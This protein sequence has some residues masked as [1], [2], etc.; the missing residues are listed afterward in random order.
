MIS[1][2]PSFERVHQMCNIWSCV[3]RSYPLK[4]HLWVGAYFSK[5]SIKC[6]YLCAS[7]STAYFCSHAHTF[8]KL[9]KA[10]LCSPAFTQYAVTCF[11]A[12]CSDM[13]FV[14]PELNSGRDQVIQ[15]SV[16]RPLSAVHDFL[17]G[18]YLGNRV[19]YPDDIWYVR[20]ARAEVAR[21]EFG[22]CTCLLST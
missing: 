10:C 5:Q 16:R 18:A 8:L 22:R 9:A 21:A 12:I 4:E 19:T 13:L 1:L 7:I 6:L 2:V 15:M 17:S 3:A 20:G 14:S 11:Y